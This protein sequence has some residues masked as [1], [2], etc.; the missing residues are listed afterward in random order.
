M[1]RAV[2]AAALLLG[3]AASSAAQAPSIAGAVASARFVAQAR[4]ITLATV[5]LRGEGEAWRTRLVLVT[6]D[7]SRVQLRLDT[8]YATPMTAQWTIARAGPRDVFAVNVGQFISTMPWGWVVL[9]GHEYLAPAHGPLSTAVAGYDGRTAWA[10]GD[11]AVLALR[12]TRPQW[13]FQ[14]YP[15]LLAGSRVPAPLRVEDSGV[16]LTHRDARLAMGRRANGTLLF[17]MTRFDALGEGAGWIPFGLTVP[18]MAEVMQALGATDAVLL[19]G[20]LSA[21][22]MLRDA[23]GNPR[24]WAGS[25]KVPLGLLGLG[26]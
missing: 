10:H 18:E 5:P 1:T 25:R 16:N 20:G 13:A 6:V 22:L 2:I 3:A 17:A 14:S 19:D 7:P 8:A 26:K 12:G 11:S 21:Q 15:T 23:R 9:G 4:G 24:K